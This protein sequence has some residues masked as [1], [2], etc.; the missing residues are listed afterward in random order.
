MTVTFQIQLNILL[1][2]FKTVPF[3]KLVYTF[4]IIKYMFEGFSDTVFLLTALIM[5]KQFVSRIISFCYS[6]YQA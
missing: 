5:N 6:H 2:I 1:N 3:P 4:L